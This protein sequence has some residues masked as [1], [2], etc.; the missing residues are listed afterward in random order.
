MTVFYHEVALGRWQIQTV[1]SLGIPDRG[2]TVL[3]HVTLT[4]GDV[5]AID[6]ASRRGNA[7]S[8]PTVG[9]NASGDAALELA[10]RLLLP[11]A[12]VF[13]RARLP[14]RQHGHRRERT[15]AEVTDAVPGAASDTAGRRGARRSRAAAARRAGLLH[16]DRGAADAESSGPQPRPS[17]TGGRGLS[18]QFDGRDQARRRRSRLLKVRIRLEAMERRRPGGRGLRADP[19]RADAAGSTRP[20]GARPVR[21]EPYAGAARHAVRSDAV[22]PRR[23]GRL[24][25]A[26]AVCGGSTSWPRHGRPGWTC[27]TCCCALRD[28]RLARQT[29]RAALTGESD[30]DAAGLYSGGS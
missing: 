14:A 2:G 15:I 13:Q 21:T 1:R 8:T 17:W 5:D 30:G 23:P 4:G 3:L 29:R 28:R 18:A 22:A 24:E 7:G 19:G 26:R 12:A 16:P 11:R 25:H 27:A 9:L 20:A 10:G 6:L